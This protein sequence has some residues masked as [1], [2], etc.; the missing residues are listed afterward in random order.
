MTTSWLINLALFG[1]SYSAVI[2]WHYATELAHH[3]T[4]PET[5]RPTP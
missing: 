1:V 2:T 4:T 3:T 5:E